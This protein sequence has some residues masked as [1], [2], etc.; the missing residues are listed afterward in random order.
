[1]HG[2]NSF[3]QSL[4]VATCV[5]LLAACEQAPSA[6]AADQ[7][8]APSVTGSNQTAESS[9]VIV[10]RAA[11]GGKNPAAF[12]MPNWSISNETGQDIGALLIELEWRTKTGSILE[13]VSALGTLID[14]FT[15]GKHKDLSLNGYTAACSD[16]QLVAR[17]YACRN[18]D[19]VRVPCPGPLRAE[20]AGGVAIDLSAAV[21]G[22]MK[23]AAES[24]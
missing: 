3:T 15:A 21:E 7:K 12:C 20:T 16:L 8:P 24:N 6:L 1:M 17:T 18:A 11:A 19:T 13:P 14:R 9:G 10:I 4:V 23:G 5:F 2:S 22:R